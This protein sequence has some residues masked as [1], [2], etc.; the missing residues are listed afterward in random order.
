MSWIGQTEV[1]PEEEKSAL[2]Q[3]SEPVEEVPRSILLNISYLALHQLTYLELGRQYSR[4][5]FKHPLKGFLDTKSF[6]KG[7][8]SGGVC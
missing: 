1:N 3:D 4:P 5:G 6:E 2:I 8:A 7:G